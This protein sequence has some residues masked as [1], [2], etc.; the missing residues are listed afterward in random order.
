MRLIAPRIGCLL[1]RARLA[2]AGWAL[3]AE[4]EQH[5]IVGLETE[6]VRRIELDLAHCIH[7]T[8]NWSPP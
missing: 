2:F 3:G 4:R 7:S 5:N 6:F 1:E 8:T